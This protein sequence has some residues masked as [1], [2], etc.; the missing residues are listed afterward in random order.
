MLHLSTRLISN[1]VTTHFCSFSKLLFPDDFCQGAIGN[2]DTVLL[3]K[4]FMDPLY[5][6]LALMIKPGQQL[7]IDFDFVF[8]DSF[9]YLS[10]LLNNRSHRVDAHIQVTGNP[11]NPHALLVKQVYRLAFVGCNHKN[12]PWLW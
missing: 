10:L 4:Y 3:G 11:A 1:P 5:P 8:S 12:L 7:R 6:A 2:T 9:G